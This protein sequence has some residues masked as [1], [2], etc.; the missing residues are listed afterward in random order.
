MKVYED[1][2]KGNI[3]IIK[4][5]D[6]GETKI[7]TPEVGATFEVY[8]KSAGSYKQQRKTER[9]ILVCDENGYA[10]SK[11]MPYGV[12][13]VH[14]TSGWEGRELLMILMYS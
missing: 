9:D 11:D 1:V 2:D 5:T 10:K 6:N 3:A 13:T 7:E 12:Y 14:Q 8:L 4:H